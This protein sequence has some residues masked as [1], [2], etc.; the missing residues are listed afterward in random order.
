M[1]VIS[2]Y[3]ELSYQILQVKILTLNYQNV[4]IDWN[5]QSYFEMDFER[6][7]TFRKFLT[8]LF[9]NHLRKK[10]FYN[11]NLFYIL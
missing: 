11:M 10:C 3:F 6:K 8:I 7:K 9:L 5:N 1:P 2:S 4:K